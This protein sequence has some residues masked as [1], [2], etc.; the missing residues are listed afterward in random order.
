MRGRQHER[1]IESSQG[2]PCRIRIAVFRQSPEDFRPLFRN[3]RACPAGRDVLSPLKRRLR[4][5][6][7]EQSRRRRRWLRGKDA[8]SARN[9]EKPA[10][11]VVSREPSRRQRSGRRRATSPALA[12]R[13]TPFSSACV[14]PLSTGALFISSQMTMPKANVSTFSFTFSRRNA[15]CGGRRRGG[16][17]AL[18][19]GGG[20][21]RDGG[22]GGPAAGGW[23]RTGAM[24]T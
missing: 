23:E 4:T 15:S 14:R 6:L 20:G 13:T 12:P 21:G 17:A 11:R 18:G 1:A 16:G 24:Y 2:P 9:A 8:G 3:L 19:R 7:N 22:R 10:S 5:R